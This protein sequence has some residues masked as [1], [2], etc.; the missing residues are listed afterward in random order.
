MRILNNFKHF[1]LK[2]II[3]LM[4]KK[5]INSKLKIFYNEI[6]GINKGKFIF[7]FEFCDDKRR[8]DRPLIW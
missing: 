8:A 6:N 1:E 7:F 3:I 4:I 2:K 5:L